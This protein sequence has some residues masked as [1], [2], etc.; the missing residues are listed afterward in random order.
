M[1]G[2]VLDSLRRTLV[3]PDVPRGLPVL[4]TARVQGFLACAC[5]LGFLI[6]LL[7]NQIHPVIVY[8]LQLFFTL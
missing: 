4:S 8:F 7:Q 3:I 1:L 2:T 5:A 6:L